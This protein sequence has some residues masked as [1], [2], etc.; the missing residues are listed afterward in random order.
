MFL[1]D[2]DGIETVLYLAESG[3]SI[4]NIFDKNFQ[5]NGQFI[6]DSLVLKIPIIHLQ[7]LVKNYL[8]LATNFLNDSEIKNRKL[9]KQIT[10]LKISD[11][12]EKV[13]NFLLE[14]SFVKGQK[15]KNINLAP[16]KA[17]IASFL[18]IKPETLS[19]IFKKLTKDKEI[20]VEKNSVKILKEDSL[21]QYCDSAIA[22]KCHHRE[23]PFCKY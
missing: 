2:Q 19:R 23:S 15:S 21:C 6:E 20:S 3:E 10:Q 13:G 9:F 22:K 7:D 4:C 11:A 8:N 18:G 16:S 12:K 1:I 14:K 5:A 17:V